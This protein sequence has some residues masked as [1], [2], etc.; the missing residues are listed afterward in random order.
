MIPEYVT[1]E[2]ARE[3]CRVDST[4]L[5]DQLARLIQSASSAVKNYLKSAYPFQPELD[6]MGDIELDSSGN[7]IYAVD[8]AG[9]KIMRP[10]VKWAT[11]ILV[12]IGL[13]Q[14]EGEAGIINPQW[15]HGY[16][17]TV[18]ISLLYPLRTPAMA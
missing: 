3:H 18:V 17:P 5:D 7:V 9:D 6:S 8:S 4:D 11:L 13:T 10:E 15:S 16:L 2:E 14:T 12:A 1:L